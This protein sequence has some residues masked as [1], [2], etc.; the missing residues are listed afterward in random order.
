MENIEKI[1]K[2]TFMNLNQDN[3]DDIEA[4]YRPDVVFK[5]PFNTIHGLDNLKQYF[6]EMYQNVRQCSFQFSNTIVQG[7]NATLFWTMSLYHKRINSGNRIDVP[8][9]S[10]IQF[11]DKISL[12][13]DYFDAGAL[14]YENLPIIGYLIKQIKAQV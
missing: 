4:L 13:H 12:H 9:A 7:Q 5:D 2:Q 1:F 14:I 11:S 6:F 8:G 3:I 10:H